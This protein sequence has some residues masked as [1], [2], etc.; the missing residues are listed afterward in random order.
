M[1]KATPEP[2]TL[3]RYEHGGGRL[4]KEEPRTLVADFYDEPDRELF[5]AMRAKLPALLAV[6]EAA[7]DPALLSSSAPFGSPP[8]MAQMRLRAALAP[9]TTPAKADK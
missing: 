7:S 4:Y 3:T 6:V 5:Y 2:L 9:L 1:S 8:H